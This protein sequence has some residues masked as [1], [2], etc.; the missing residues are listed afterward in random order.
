M[1]QPEFNLMSG[2][3]FIDFLGLIGNMPLQFS[4]IGDMPLK[5]T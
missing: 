1:V 4:R 3:R 5:I 2:S